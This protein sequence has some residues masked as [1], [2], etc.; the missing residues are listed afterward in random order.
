MEFIEFLEN[1]KTSY[2]E[3]LKNLNEEMIAS[4]L[5]HMREARDKEQS[6][7]ILGNGGSAASASHWVCDFN[8]GAEREGRRPFKVSSLCDNTPIVTALGN[9]VSYDSV[10]SAQLKNYLSEGDLV[11][12]LSVS[13][14]SANLVEAVNYARSNGAYTFS[15]I[16]DYNGRLKEVCDESF[17]VPSKNYGIV[18]DVHMYLAHVLSQ[19]LAG[20]ELNK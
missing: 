10:F 15:V 14:S 11:I 9:D 20:A 18:E 8:K 5:T 19:Y 17:I 12:T 2:V 16:G 6:I 13:G 3:T 1:Y 7:F 4:L